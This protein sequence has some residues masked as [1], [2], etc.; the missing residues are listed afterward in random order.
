[1]GALETS[2]PV[3]TLMRQH[4]ITVLLEAVRSGDR[5][6]TDELFGAVYEEL[7][8]LARSNR[9]RWVGNQTMN[10]TALIHEAYIKMSG[11][12][13]PGWQNRIHFYA[14]AS[15]AM[16]QILV[17]YS[18]SANA[19]KR[20]GGEKPL[21]LDDSM[22]I[23]ES[24]AEELLQ[25]TEHLI[26]LERDNPRRCRVVECRVFGGMSVPE[27]AA[28]LG[29][30]PATVKREWQIAAALLRRNMLSGEDAHEPDRD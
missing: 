25:L 28:A 22:V 15:H 4:S 5:L 12:E 14:T 24:T 19:A 30:S 21:P 29:I 3:V 26:P 23:S 18:E 6:A 9:R 1:M 17:N 10:T 20:G 27:T 2:S 13:R 16:R 8:T 7:R 11:Q